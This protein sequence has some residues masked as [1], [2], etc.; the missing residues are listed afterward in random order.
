MQWSQVR[1]E[2]FSILSKSCHNLPAGGCRS[3]LS[4]ISCQISF[5]TFC[6]LLHVQV[7]RLPRPFLWQRQRRVKLQLDSTVLMMFWPGMPTLLHARWCAPL[8]CAANALRLLAVVRCAASRASAS[9]GQPAGCFYKGTSHPCKA[10]LT[11]VQ[12]L[13]V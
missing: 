7:L 2:E 9:C 5:V 1:P 6:V 11:F 3:L 13:L 10:V 8:S 12:S 4:C